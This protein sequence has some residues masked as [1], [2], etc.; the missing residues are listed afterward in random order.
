MGHGLARAGCCDNSKHCSG[1][2]NPAFRESAESAQS[3]VLTEIVGTWVLVHAEGLKEAMEVWGNGRVAY[4]TKQSDN[5]DSA[6][7]L[8]PS[9]EKGILQPTDPNISCKGWRYR[10]DRNDAS[11]RYDLLR[12]VDGHLLVLRWAGSHWITME[13]V[14]SSRNVPPCFWH[15]DCAYWTRSTQVFISLAALPAV[16]LLEKARIDNMLWQAW[17]VTAKDGLNKLTPVAMVISLLLDVLFTR[18]VAFWGYYQGTPD[19]NVTEC[20]RISWFAVMIPVYFMFFASFFEEL[21]QDS[22]PQD[23]ALRYHVLR[24]GAFDGL[25][26]STGLMSHVLPAMLL[27]AVRC[28]RDEGIQKNDISSQNAVSALKAHVHTED[29]PI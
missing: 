13:G 9:L 11:G 8:G 1:L 16:Y 28:I 27:T 12:I 20:S 29:M 3:E 2:G 19:F 6:H 7:L 17:T 4:A 18:T 23:S 10:V 22:E 24:H 15:G 26:L 14:R 25:L 5:D 21:D